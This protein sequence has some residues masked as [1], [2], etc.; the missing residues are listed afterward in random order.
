MADKTKFLNDVYD[1]KTVAQTQALYDNWSSSYDDEVGENGYITPT[2]IA[3]ALAKLLP[4][5]NA[6]ILDFG[7]GTG[8][9][10][11][12]LSAAGFSTIDGCDMSAGMLAVAQN[13]HKY[14]QLW[15]ADPDL[16]LPVKP[17]DY[18]AITAVGVISIG[19]AP[20][21]TMDMLIG[22][23]APGALLAFSFN[24]HTLEDPRFEAQVQKYLDQRVCTQILREKGEH[25]P[26]IGL[27]SVIYVLKRQ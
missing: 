19:A 22:A 24:D 6:P 13:K 1:L 27:R 12:A 21:E 23:L 25:L 3:V 16:P 14:R 2:G 20:P 15:R 8:I 7:C 10:G 11:A 26:G 18:A 4:D 9:S 5:R 17:G